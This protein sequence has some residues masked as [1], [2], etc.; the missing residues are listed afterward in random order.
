M[1]YA[2]SR[3]KRAGALTTQGKRSSKRRTAAASLPT[4]LAVRSPTI[5]VAMFAPTGQVLSA[6]SLLVVPA[7]NTGPPAQQRSTGC[8]SLRQPDENLREAV[9]RWHWR[10]RLWR[11]L[12]LLHDRLRLEIRPGAGRDLRLVSCWLPAVPRTALRDAIARQQTD[13]EAVLVAWLW[14]EPVGCLLLA[15][16]DHEPV[17]AAGGS[18]V[19]IDEVWVP[20]P[21]RRRGIGIALVTAAEI[22]ASRRGRAEVRVMLSSVPPATR[23]WWLRR[24]YIATDAA[25]SNHLHKWLTP[26]SSTGVG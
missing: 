19:R 10:G 21:L 6:G 4:H 3:A 7:A 17:P 13:R 25:G 8:R 9:F 1:E 5:D 23:T 2:E 18:A 15:E 22:S 12:R 16:T 24:G 11:H 14:G 20:V 26:T